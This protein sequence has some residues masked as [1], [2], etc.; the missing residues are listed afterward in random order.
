MKVPAG[1]VDWE[2]STQQ[3]A[4]PSARNPHACRA[5]VAGA[6]Q[7]RIH[8]GPIGAQLKACSLARDAAQWRTRDGPWQTHSILVCKK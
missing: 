2:L 8:Y 6:P 5:S 1:V 7:E 4:L 3:M